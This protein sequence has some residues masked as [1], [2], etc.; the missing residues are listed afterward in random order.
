VVKDTR[1]VVLKDTQKVV[2]TD[3]QKSLQRGERK[4]RKGS[5]GK[6]I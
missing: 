1:V 3:T 4:R 6:G 2:I 5:K